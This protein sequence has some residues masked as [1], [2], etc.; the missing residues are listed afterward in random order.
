[1]MRAKK[2]PVPMSM[3]LCFILVLAFFPSRF[4]TV[5][6]QEAS[7]LKGEKEKVSYAVGLNL[8]IQLRTQAIDIDADLVTQGLRDALFAGKPLLSEQEVRGVLNNL[9]SAMKRKQVAL[10]GE[11]VMRNRKEGEAFLAENKARDGIVA[12]ESGLQYKILKAGDGKKPT[13]DD[14]VV[15]HYRGT[16]IDGTEFDSSYKHNQPATFRVNKVIK[17]WTEALQLMPVGSKWQL[18]IPSNLAY[19]QRGTGRGIGPNTT[20]VFE[21]D[22]IS[23][24]DTP[25]DGARASERRDST[26]PAVSHS[27][28]PGHDARSEASVNRTIAATSALTGITVSFKVDPRLTRGLYMGDRWVSPPTYNRVGEGKSVSVEARAHGR[29]TMGRPLDI[30]ADWIP[31]DPEMVTVTPNRSHEVRITVQR[32]GQSSLRVTSQGVS[33]ELVIRATDQGNTLQLEIAQGQ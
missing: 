13:A 25:G 11:M 15:C 9:Q 7:A 33:K 6:A 17:G 19:G 23:I 20:L 22:L 3:R 24:E 2:Q 16:F 28:I 31:T 5:A 4:E 14:T 10:H 18:F 30:S 32:A 29:D 8:G 1:M 26:P 12:L 21:V 27:Q